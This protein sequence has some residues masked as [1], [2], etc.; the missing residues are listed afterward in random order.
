MTTTITLPL[1]ALILDADIQPRETMSSALIH[2]Y[3]ELYRDGQTLAPIT[4]FLE[5]QTYW[6]ADGFHR[7]TAARE[8]GLSEITVDLEVGTKRQAI[9]YSCGANKHGKARTPEDKRRA[10]GRLLADPEW[11]TWSD[12]E[13]ARHCGVSHEFVRRLRPS[14]P[15]VDS[16]DARRTYRTKH[17]TMAMMDTRRIGG[18]GG[19]SAAEEPQSST[20]VNIL[21][22]QVVRP[23]VPTVPAPRPQQVTLDMDGRREHGTEVLDTDEIPR[24]S[25]EA[26][27]PAMA[28]LAAEGVGSPSRS[29]LPPP[30]YKPPDVLRL[31]GDLCMALRQLHAEAPATAPEVWSLE[32]THEYIQTSA[33]LIDQLHALQRALEHHRLAVDAGELIDPAVSQM[34]SP[35]A[36]GDAS[37]VS[38]GEAERALLE[39]ADG[40]GRV[41]Q[42]RDGQQAVWERLKALEAEGLDD[43]QIVARL[44]AEEGGR[45]WNR[46]SLRALRRAHTPEDRHPLLNGGAP[47]TA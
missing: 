18:T 24:T 47:M 16:K 8:A 7:V 11:R 26:A 9:H 44:N 14:L 39:P 42:G 25:I 46:G 30:Q 27:F 20:P 29:N 17:G 12:R 22:E 37:H 28:E 5:G 21:G 35:H 36:G 33:E 19:T 10:V 43:V 31:M 23:A 1:D 4:V 45:R 32:L 41:G 38:R 34:P 2:E 3:A 6:V 40:S 13:I 15:T